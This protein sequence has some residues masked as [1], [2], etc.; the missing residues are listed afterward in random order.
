MA[1][2][3]RVQALK[4]EREEEDEEVGGIEIEEVSWFWMV[5]GALI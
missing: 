2:P 1:T 5:T 4:N 3:G